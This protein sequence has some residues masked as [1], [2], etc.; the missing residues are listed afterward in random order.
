MT[1]KLLNPWLKAFES[2]RVFMES[3]FKKVVQP[4]ERKKFTE[5]DI[6]TCGFVEGAAQNL[7]K[8]AHKVQIKNATVTLIGVT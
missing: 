5:F 4:K 1:L 2:K 6:G 8:N 7:V 3:N